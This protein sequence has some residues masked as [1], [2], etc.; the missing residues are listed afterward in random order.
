MTFPGTSLYR[1]AMEKG[2]F[3]NEQDYYDQ[4]FRDE[5]Y[6]FINYTGIKRDDI[7]GFHRVARA[8]NDWNYHHS[9]ASHYQKALN[10]VGIKV[11]F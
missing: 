5:R 3:E 4:F 1:W 9:T 10:E 11:P 2:Y 6:H 7:I 8:L